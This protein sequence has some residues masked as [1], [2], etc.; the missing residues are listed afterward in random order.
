M[1]VG[2][3]WGGGVVRPSVDESLLRKGLQG[4]GHL[5]IHLHADGHDLL[6]AESVAT[7]FS[8]DTST[9][10]SFSIERSVKAVPLT[11]ALLAG[12]RTSAVVLAGSVKE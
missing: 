12:M 10:P 7:P 2:G 3:V 5:E 8:N 9:M 6:T 11:V 4:D 1:C